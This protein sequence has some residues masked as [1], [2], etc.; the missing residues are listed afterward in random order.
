MANEIN[1][2]A[3]PPTQSGNQSQ[4][5]NPININ[6]GKNQQTQGGSTVNSADKLTVTDSAA[7]LQALD[8][9]IASLP[10]VDEQR[11]AS[12]RTAIENGDYKV[13]AASTALKFLNLESA[14]HRT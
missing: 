12:I 10:V 6:N 14:L 11:V 1:R 9:Q 5:I 8:Q 7:K 13:D 4:S 2:V 3:T